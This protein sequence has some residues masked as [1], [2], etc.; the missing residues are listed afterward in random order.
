M[1]LLGI[2]A[3]NT[4]K[5][6]LSW[7]HLTPVIPYWNVEVTIIEKETSYVLMTSQAESMPEIIVGKSW[8]IDFL[9]KIMIIHDIIDKFYN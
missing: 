2:D 9:I 3:S 4:A 6:V 8:I 7:D 1:T 5:R